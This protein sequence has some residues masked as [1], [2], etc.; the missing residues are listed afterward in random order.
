MRIL[1]SSVWR[2]PIMAFTLL[3]GAG[4]LVTAQG[5]EISSA[6]TAAN[7][8]NVL[9]TPKITIIAMQDWSWGI[10]GAI[11]YY[12]HSFTGAPM[13]AMVQSLTVQ[14]LALYNLDDGFYLRSSGI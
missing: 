1:T 6:G 14:P 10:T 11:V 13:R 5:Q 4:Y 7:A 12:S 2:L 9:L 8:S 3:C